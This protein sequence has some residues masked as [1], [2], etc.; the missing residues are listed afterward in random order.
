MIWNALLLALREIRRSLMRSFLTILGIVIGVAAVIVMV[1]IGRGATAQVTE[2]I[3]SLGSNLLIITPGQRMGMGQRSAAPAF[4]E[5][6]VEGA[7][8]QDVIDRYATEPAG[9]AGV[10]ALLG[11]GIPI[12]DDGSVVVGP[13]PGRGQPLDGRIGWWVGVGDPDVSR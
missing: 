8:F 13:C 1:T 2:Q 10:A 9:G 7:I 6:D 11:G 3:A 4:D 12:P 5:D